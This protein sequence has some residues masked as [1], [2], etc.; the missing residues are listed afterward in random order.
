[1]TLTLWRSLGKKEQI[2]LVLYIKTVQFIGICGLLFWNNLIYLYIMLFWI[3]LL[4]WL[5]SNHL[6]FRKRISKQLII[7]FCVKH[8]NIY[9]KR[10]K[11]LIELKMSRIPSHHWDSILPTED[12]TCCC[13]NILCS[14]KHLNTQ[15]LY[16]STFRY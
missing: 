8:F 5:L 14:R 11:G 10:I 9:E 16:I 6:I 7:C 12:E 4:A 1:M 13:D 2:Y 3:Y 15:H